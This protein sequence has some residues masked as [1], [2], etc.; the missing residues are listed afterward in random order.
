MKNFLLLIA[1]SLTITSFTYGSEVGNTAFR[2]YERLACEPPSKEVLSKMVDLIKAGKTEEA[3]SYAIN[4]RGFYECTVKNW[5]LIQTN[6]AETDQVPLNDYCATVIGAVHDDIPINKLLYDNVIYISETVAA[7]TPYSLNNNDHYEKIQEQ[8]LEFTKTLVK[9]K[10]TEVTGF[11]EDSGLLTTRAFAEAFLQAGTNRRALRHTLRNYICHDIEEMRDTSI[12]DFYVG[13]D[14][15][16]APGGNPK[17]Y[18]ADCKGCHTG[19]DSLRGAWAHF[20][21]DE[22]TKHYIYHKDVVA[23][24]Y[25]V[26][27]DNFSDGYRN[28]DDSWKNMWLEGVNK[29]YGWPANRTK[30]KGIREFGQM[31]AEVEYFSTC[32]AERTFKKVCMADENSSLSQKIIENMAKEFKKD[33]YN[34]KKLF[35]KTVTSCTTG[36]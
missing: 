7:E 19:M 10:Q 25:G 4:T 22:E 3:A 34:L 6:E 15:E 21:F 18:Q 1:L 36:E 13:R 16:R 14:V 23:E 24:K 30:G 33:N 32:M 35:A 27:A 20:D 28:I 26:N 29:K 11:A 9:K 31:F 17:D 5:C 2:I 8:G 12:S